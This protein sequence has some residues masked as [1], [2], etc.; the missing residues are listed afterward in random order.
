MDLIG[1]KIFTNGTRQKTSLLTW[2]PR[3]KTQILT[4]TVS[5][6]GSVIPKIVRM[7]FT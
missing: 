3:L 4:F 6:N 2:F 5:M 7:H 1:M